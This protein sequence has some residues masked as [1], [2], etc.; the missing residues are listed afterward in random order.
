MMIKEFSSFKD[1]AGYVYYKD[2]ILYRNVSYN[3]KQNYDCL[4]NSGLYDKLQQKQYL[5]PTTEASLD[6]QDV[7]KTLKP[8]MIEFISYPYEW[9]FSQY[10]DAAL[11][12]LK[13]QKQA[14]LHS[15]SLKDASAYNIQFKNGKPILIDTLSF[16]ILNE[17]QP[18]VAYKQ[19]CQHFLAPLALMSYKDVRLSQ[20]MKNN[21]DGI[22]LDLASQLLPK[23]IN[24]SL[25]V[26]IHMNSIFQNKYKKS[27][28]NGIN[29][30]TMSKEKHLALIENLLKIITTLKN[31]HKSTEWENYYEFTNYDN[32]SFETKEK[33]IN[34]L[35]ENFSKVKMLWDIGANNG[36]FTRIAASG[37][38]R[39][40]FAVAFDI[41]SQA[42]EKNYN[43][44]KKDQET[45]I[46]PLI[47]DLL[48]PSPGIGWHNKERTEIE[49]RG[50]PDVV[51]ALALIHHLCI[52]Q[53]IPFTYL[54]SYL[55]SLSQNLIIEFVDKEDSQVQKLLS[56][57]KDIY[58]WYNQEQF[59][60]DFSKYFTIAKKVQIPSTLR[61]VYLM[62]HLS[63]ND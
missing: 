49:K 55:S 7:Y 32:T 10:K 57:R 45:N 25:F 41:D 56:S 53:N 6:T 44:Q 2:G 43:K 4:I 22:P 15:M 1:P 12:T 31:P 47:L 54:A 46:L 34:D 51:L 20:L 38:N 21:I 60:A 27:Q 16:E 14:L 62:T 5:I 35:M 18:W 48:N 17:K 28:K 59:E 42:V 26:H 19:F 3:Y 13:I 36:H 29:L 24:P 52:S 61:T 33:I 11:L 40:I 50:K 23:I 37:N 8:E 39:K 9:S 58:S 63:N 30:Q